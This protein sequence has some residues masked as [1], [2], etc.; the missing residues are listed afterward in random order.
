MK[1]TNHEQ[2]NTKEQRQTINK[3]INLRAHDFLIT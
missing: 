2:T 1:Q 3:W